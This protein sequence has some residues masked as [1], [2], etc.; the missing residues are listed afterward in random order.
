TMKLKKPIRE[1]ITY[2]RLTVTDG[3]DACLN[4]STP[5]EHILACGHLIS[6]ALPHRACAPNCWHITNDDE[7]PNYVVH[8]RNEQEVSTQPFYCNACVETEFE[9]LIPDR[10]TAAEAE[11]D[12]AQ[13]RAEQAEARG[14][15][16]K[17]RKCYIAL[18]VTSVPCFSDRRSPLRYHPTEDGHPF[19]LS[20]PR[21]GKNMFED[22]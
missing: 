10:L 9:P 17:Y 11:E 15:S 2:P 22:V 16:T 1:T 3:D 4:Y 12:R 6:T 21:T 7:N 14:K 5:Y 13:V 20:L 19:D 8:R 18:K